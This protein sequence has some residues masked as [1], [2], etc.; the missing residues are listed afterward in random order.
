M[1]DLATAPAAAATHSRLEHVPVG[2]FAMVMGLAGLTLATMRLEHVSG[3]HTVAPGLLLGLTGLV[4]AAIAALYG[5]KAMKYPKAVRA[6]WNHPV[7][8]AFFP[9]ASISLILIATALTPMHDGWGGIFW[10]VGTALQLVLTLAVVSAW[11]GH[12][13]F[14]AAHLNPAWFIPAVG[15]ILVPIAGMRL[16]H[17]EISWFFFSVG[18]LFWVILATLVFN[19]LIFHAPLPER[20]MPTLMILIAPPAVGFISW[21]ALTGGIDPF[22]RILYY[23]G[24]LFALVFATQIR[25]VS[26]LPFMITWWAYSFPLAALTISTL[27]YGHAVGAEGLLLA[28]RILYG[29]LVAV[30]VML[31]VRTGMAMARGDICKPE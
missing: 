1:S 24:V 7:R 25:T 21:N 30:I 18:I 26:R 8:I 6:D 4:F 3:F 23:S 9:A 10:S 22:A 17:T 15:N 13:T 12:R 11:I 29:L 19:R 2:L 20:L 16:G 31:L 28:G 14:E 27:A 5:T